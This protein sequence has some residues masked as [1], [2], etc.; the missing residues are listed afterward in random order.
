M[1][2]KLTST[3]TV[4]VTVGGG[5]NKL[6]HVQKLLDA[7]ADKVSIGFEKVVKGL[8]Y[9]IAKK[10][11]SQ[12]LSVT[13]DVQGTKHAEAGLDARL[14]Q[15]EGAGELILQSIRQDGTMDGYNLG[16][17]RYVDEV[18]DL[19]IPVVASGGCSG[20]P[21]ML[22][23]INAGASAVAAGALFQFTDATPRGAAEYLHSHDV[24]V[25]L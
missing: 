7:G 17:I 9:E 22:Q 18:A 20:Y 3:T 21:D 5:V 10:Y 8:A 14:C 11:G 15:R 4:P 19:F 23:A 12:C 1:I 2:E 13:L 25:R 6:E 16:L 24:E